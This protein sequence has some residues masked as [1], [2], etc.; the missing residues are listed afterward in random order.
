MRECNVP[1][2]PVYSIKPYQACMSIRLPRVYRPLTNERKKH[3]SIL[4]ATCSALSL[5]DANVYTRFVP[6]PLSPAGDLPS[7]WR[8]H[9]ARCSHRGR[10]CADFSNARSCH[11]SRSS[12]STEE[13]LQERYHGPQ[14]LGEK[15]GNDRRH[16]EPDHAET[17]PARA[18]QPS[19]AWRH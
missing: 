14:L 4:V 3:Q 7:L 6:V 1:R 16:Q 19:P 2:G 18:S 5:Q 8:C 15:A 17:E 11:H 10:S 9:P 13:L 12:S